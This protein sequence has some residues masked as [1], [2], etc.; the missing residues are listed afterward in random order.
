MHRQNPQDWEKEQR[1]CGR[2]SQRF[3]E[4]RDVC[5]NGATISE[6]RNKEKAVVEGEDG[7]DFGLNFDPAR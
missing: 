2:E 4:H 5:V 6:T 1:A 7:D 3:Q